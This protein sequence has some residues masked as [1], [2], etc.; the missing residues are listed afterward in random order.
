M[1]NMF[2]Q[3]NYYRYYYTES[4]KKASQTLI[5]SSPKLV[6]MENRC[7]ENRFDKVNYHQYIYREDSP[8]F[9]QV[10]DDSETL[11]SREATRH[12]DE[13]L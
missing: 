7:L 1:A 11:A 6:N 13:L 9:G 8:A 12:S 10:I 3:D 2:L 4:K 5:D